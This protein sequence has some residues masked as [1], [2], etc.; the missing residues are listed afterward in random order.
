MSKLLSAVNE[1]AADASAVV[2][3]MPFGEVVLK[4]ILAYASI[5]L[6]T[7]VIILS[8]YILN[9]VTSKKK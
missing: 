5:F 3:E 8:I 1:V 2:T 4:S 7:G 6:V 9:K